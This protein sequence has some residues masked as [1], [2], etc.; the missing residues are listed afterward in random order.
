[1]LPSVTSYRRRMRLTM[2]LFPLPVEPMNAMVSPF[3]AVKLTSF[4]T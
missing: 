1:M 3:L 2:V 4:K